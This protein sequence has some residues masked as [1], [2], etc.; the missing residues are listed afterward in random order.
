MQAW[1]AEENSLKNIKNLTVQKLLTDNVH[2]I[3]LN[4]TIQGTLLLKLKTTDLYSS[5]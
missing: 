4:Q 5:Y 1:W 2:L 3:F